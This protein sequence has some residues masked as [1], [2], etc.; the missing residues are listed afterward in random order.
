MSLS[1][2]VVTQMPLLLAQ[3]PGGF[4]LPKILH[5]QDLVPHHWPK[6]ESLSHPR[7][8]GSASAA[9]SIRC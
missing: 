4:I 5:L 1:S 6:P 3:A 9:E 7:Q 8:L 2:L